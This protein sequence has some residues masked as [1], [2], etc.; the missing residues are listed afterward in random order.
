MVFSLKIINWYALNKRDLPWRDTRNPYKIWLSEVIM[1]QTR[2]IQGLDYYHKFVKHYPTVTDLANTPE[3]KIMK[4]WQ[5]LGYYSRARNLHAAAQFIRDHHE[6]RFPATYEEILMLKGVGKYTAAAIASFAYDLP[7]P[8]VDGNVMRVIARYFGI[9]KPI[10]STQ[11]LKEIEM[12]VDAVFDRDNP[13]IFN[14]AIMEFGA[15]Q[16]KPGKPDC[17]VCVLQDACIA[18]ATG[19]TETLPVKEKKTKIRERHFC[20]LVIRDGNHTYIQKRTGNDIWKN[21]YQFP[22]LETEQSLTE[23]QWLQ[24]VEEALKSLKIKKPGISGISGEVKHQLTHRTIRA[25]FCEIEAHI[26]HIPDDWIRIPVETLEEYA[27]PVLI[28]RYLD[29]KKHNLFS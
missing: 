9:D 5:G 10:N 24:Q 28:S 1:Q 13:G 18:Y 21:M 16:C 4:D 2:V 23:P 11:G 14:Q 7:Y 17:S 26:S 15:L 20:Y 22:L 3:E 29:R 12:A 27:V 6:G 19:Q 25:R 8:V